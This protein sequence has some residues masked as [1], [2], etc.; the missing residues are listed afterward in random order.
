[1]VE[2]GDMTLPFEDI[3]WH[4]GRLWCTSDYGLWTLENNRIV[5][6]DVPSEIRVC[7]GNLSAADGVMLLAG[8]N[9]AAYHD[10]ERWH[11]IFLYHEMARR[12][13]AENP[14]SAP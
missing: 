6:A 1:M 12:L 2:R 8:T 3:V 14:E 4:A 10:G 13:K 9:G 11:S 7:A 5:R